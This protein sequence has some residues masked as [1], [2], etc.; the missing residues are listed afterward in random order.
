MIAFGFDLLLFKLPASVD[1]CVVGEQAYLGR[2]MSTNGGDRKQDQV[3]C[4][5]CQSL[6]SLVGRI[7]NT[8]RH[9]PS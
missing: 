4:L 3:W 8:V 2:G 1:C 6:S 7:G 9:W 5:T